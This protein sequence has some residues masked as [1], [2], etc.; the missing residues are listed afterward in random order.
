MT[1][2]GCARRPPICGSQRLR[3]AFCLSKKL[4]AL[5]EGAVERVVDRV[6]QNAVARGDIALTAPADGHGLQCRLPVR[7]LRLRPSREAIEIE[8]HH[9]RGVKREKLA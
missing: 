3:V 6:G 8:E 5:A 4:R 7:W 9:R 1:A 2:S